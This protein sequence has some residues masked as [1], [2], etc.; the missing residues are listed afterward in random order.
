MEN[1]LVIEKNE[2]LEVK[3]YDGEG[4][5]HDITPAFRSIAGSTTPAA[6]SNTIKAQSGDTDISLDFV[7]TTKTMEFGLDPSVVKQLVALAE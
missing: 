1:K 5:A 2:E 4:V 6:V 7:A 3:V